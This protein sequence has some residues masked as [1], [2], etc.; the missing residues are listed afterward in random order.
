MY[1]E[2]ERRTIAPRS[3]EAESGARAG[4]QGGRGG[5]PQRGSGKMGRVEWVNVVE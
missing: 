5:G 3:E 4:A 2:A 1:R